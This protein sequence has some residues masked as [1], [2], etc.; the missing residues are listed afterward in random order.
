VE[1][2]DIE[3]SKITSKIAVR[4]ENFILE[5]II[6]K[7]QSS[8]NTQRKEFEKQGYKVHF[9]QNPTNKNQL[10]LY[11]SINMYR[12]LVYKYGGTIDPKREFMYQ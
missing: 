11:T 5:G 12:K 9:K 6:P 2:G 10:L 7:T 8:K 1:T 4:G 3:M